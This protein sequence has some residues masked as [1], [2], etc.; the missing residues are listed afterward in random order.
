MGAPTSS[1]LSEVF[2]QSLEH[3]SIYKIL[4]E[5]NIKAYFRYVDDI[6]IVYDSLE[7]DITHMLSLFNKLHHNLTFTM[8][9]EDDMR[10]NFLDLKIHRLTDSV[11]ASIYRKPTATDSLI[12][13]DSCH[14]M[15]HKLAGINHLVNRVISY[16][17]PAS[18]K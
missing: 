2:L 10:I 14:P 18:E 17:I 15:E 5:L 7:T 1:L 6:L 4:V 16:P 13:F 3:D 8:E 11:Y 9:L 12:H